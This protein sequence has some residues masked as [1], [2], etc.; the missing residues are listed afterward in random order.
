[1]VRLFA[2]AANITDGNPFGKEEEEEDGKTKNC[3]YL[4]VL[5]ENLLSQS[6]NKLYNTRLENVV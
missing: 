3:V 4:Q 2:P 5:S 6:L 1:M